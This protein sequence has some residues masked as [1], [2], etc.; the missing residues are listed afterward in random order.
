MAGCTFFNART[1]TRGDISCGGF[2]FFEKRDCG[3]LE[4]DLGKKERER[5]GEGEGN[6]SA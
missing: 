6:G 5:E 1:Q 3:G 4:G 2:F